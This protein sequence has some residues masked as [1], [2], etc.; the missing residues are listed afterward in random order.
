MT[1]L[2]VAGGADPLE[3]AAVDLARVLAT[4]LP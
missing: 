4:R 1:L 3:A 2:R